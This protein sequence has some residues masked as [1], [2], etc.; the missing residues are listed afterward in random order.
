MSHSRP[1]TESSQRREGRLH[2][3]LSA[4]GRYGYTEARIGWMRLQEGFSGVLTARTTGKSRTAP[5]D[6]RT[7]RTVGARTSTERMRVVAQEEGRVDTAEVNR[8]QA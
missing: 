7:A 8:W 2:V 5:E 3:R 1:S 6:Q 4:A